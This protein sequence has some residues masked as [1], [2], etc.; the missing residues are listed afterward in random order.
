LAIGEEFPF[1]MPK[2]TTY[3]AARR[4]ISNESFEAFSKL[5]EI[6]IALHLVKP[7]FLAIKYI[8][9]TALTGMH[10]LIF[11][12]ITRAV[13]QAFKFRSPVDKCQFAVPVGPVTLLADDDLSHTRFLA[14]LFCV[15]LIAINE[16][17]D[18]GILLG[19]RIHAGRSSSVVCNP[20][21][22]SAPR[23]SCDSA[24][25]GGHWSSLASIFQTA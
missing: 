20:V 10:R 22:D 17:D 7:L 15:V 23:L 19:K 8:A 13:G 4:R 2:N 6:N 12:K 25:L 5:K 16:H 24:I 18:V 14:S 11:I 9:N 1:H 3:P 21:R